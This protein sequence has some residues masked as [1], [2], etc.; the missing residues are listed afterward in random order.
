MSIV[1]FELKKEH[2]ELLK[3]LKWGLMENKFVVSAEDITDDACPFGGDN[4]YESIDLILN[5]KPENFDPL[6][7]SEPKE[8]T[9]EQIKEWDNLI[10][11]LPTALDV[12]LNMYNDKFEL[13][14]YKTKYHLR[15][16]KKIKSN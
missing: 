4:I 10:S 2:I 9:S 1:K 8:F 7:T 15:D 3:F 13:G 16:W 5:G 11:E 6:N 14:K 12:I